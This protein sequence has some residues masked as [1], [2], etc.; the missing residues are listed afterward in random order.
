[1]AEKQTFWGVFASGFDSNR[2][3]QRD[4]NA[5]PAG[6]GDYLDDDGFHY[7]E[8][9]MNGIR[10]RKAL[11]VTSFFIGSQLGDIGLCN[12]NKESYENSPLLKRAASEEKLRAFY[13]YIDLIRYPL[14][15]LGGRSSDAELYIDPMFTVR[16]PQGGIEGRRY[17]LLPAPADPDSPATFWFDHDR[18]NYPFTVNEL[19][20]TGEALYFFRDGSAAAWVNSI[21]SSVGPFGEQ[22]PHRPTLNGVYQPQSDPDALPFRTDGDRA[23]LTLMG[24]EAVDPYPD[25]DPD[26]LSPL[27]R[28]D[29]VCDVIEHREVDLGDCASLHVQSESGEWTMEDPGGN[30]LARIGKGLPA[31]DPSE[32]F[33][34]PTHLR[35]IVDYD[36]EKDDWQAH[37]YCHRPVLVTYELERDLRASER[38]A[39]NEQPPELVIDRVPGDWEREEAR[40]P[41]EITEEQA[42]AGVHVR[43]LYFTTGSN[44]SVRVEP[45]D[46][47]ERN[48][49][50]RRRNRFSTVSFNSVERTDGG[51]RAFTT[52]EPAS[53]GLFKGSPLIG[54]D[55][56]TFAEWR[57]GMIDE[58]QDKIENTTVQK[59]GSFLLGLLPGPF[60]GLSAVW[61]YAVET[62]TREES[63]RGPGAAI[64]LMQM[65]VGTV[66]KMDGVWH[67]ASEKALSTAS[68]TAT[69]LR[70]VDDGLASTRERLDALKS[71]FLLGRTE[72]P[73]DAV[74]LMNAT[75][76]ERR[77][78][79][80]QGAIAYE[81]ET[82]EQQGVVFFDRRFDPSDAGRSEEPYHVQIGPN[83]G[84][85]QRPAG[86]ARGAMAEH[87]NAFLDGV[88]QTQAYLQSEFEAPETHSA[89]TEIDQL[90]T[91]ARAIAEGTAP[92]DLSPTVAAFAREQQVADRIEQGALQRAEITE[93][94]AFLHL[95]RS[96]DVAIIPN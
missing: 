85:L 13:K 59:S 75:A 11:P 15:S 94:K 68:G 23:K 19:Q 25:P 61:E 12:N 51:E 49:A 90:A 3:T 30:L 74:L 78:R 4:G 48:D 27:E 66:F 92:I 40:L 20:A 54:Y 41:L 67:A 34:P 72:K 42:T 50:I 96:I 37:A 56:L 1:M 31:E 65:L 43:L 18:E 39:W 91:I 73:G 7:D 87:V 80:S 55:A 79:I 33:V 52:Y 8:P 95:W 60:S 82:H 32:R 86:Q 24:Y 14:S 64:A 6:Q 88:Q 84:R 58:L 29:M 83:A 9:T 45:H 62:V 70:M 57:R 17:P 28:S 26:W 5:D 10:V 76:H 46:L 44:L 16:D 81:T 77:L 47:F 21:E 35:T 71:P 2:D 69:L 38:E 63:G 22:Q 93:A 53:D 36:E 89:A